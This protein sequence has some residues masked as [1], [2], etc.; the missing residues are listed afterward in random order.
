MKFHETNLTEYNIKQQNILA[1]TSVILYLLTIVDTLTIQ[2][3]T[4]HTFPLM[5]EIDYILLYIC[6]SI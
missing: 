5:S 4:L 2:S 1:L 6:L 3:K